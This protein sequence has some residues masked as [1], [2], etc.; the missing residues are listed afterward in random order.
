MS[1]NAGNN[2]V[3]PAPLP[4]NEWMP[5]SN[6]S[7]KYI[8]VGGCDDID[9][10][11]S[12]ACND[13]FDDVRNDGNKNIYLPVLQKGKLVIYMWSVNKHTDTAEHIIDVALF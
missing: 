2:K 1:T 5:T 6:K 13:K 3:A 7:G 8:K 12:C 10:I 9:F 11:E 4:N